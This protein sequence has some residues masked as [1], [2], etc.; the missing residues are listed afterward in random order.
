[1]AKA[2]AAAAVVDERCVSVDEDLESP[3]Q[4]VPKSFSVSGFP[5]GNYKRDALSFAEVEVLRSSKPIHSLR[6]RDMIWVGVVTLLVLSMFC[7]SLMA[8]HV[9]KDSRVENSHLVDTHGSDVFTRSQIDT[10]DGVHLPEGRRLSDNLTAAGLQI[11]ATKFQHIQKAYIKGQ[12]EWVV[13]LPEKTARTVTIQGVTETKAWGV[14]A[15]CMGTIVW[16]VDCS[17][18]STECDISLE[19]QVRRLA[20]SDGIENALMARARTPNTQ[21]G[22]H[23]DRSLS[24]KQCGS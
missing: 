7:T 17:G 5:V 6:R 22:L 12:P 3:S 2:D 13:A 14:C 18:E 16:V 1:M 11:G 21:D 23:M 9:M 20:E 19:R 8:I 4:A 10:I 15:D 24:G